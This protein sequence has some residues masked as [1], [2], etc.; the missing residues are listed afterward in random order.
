MRPNLGARQRWW[1]GGS[2]FSGLIAAHALSYLVVAPDHHER[3]ELLH[4]T[5]HGNWD[6]L[7]VLAGALFI[8]GFFA[9]SNLWASPTDRDVPLRRLYRYAWT[10]LVPLQI[11]GFVALEA[12]ERLWSGGALSDLTGE[13]AFL[14]G[15]ALQVVVAFACGL[16]L[17][18]FTRLV[19]ALRGASGTTRRR[20][21]PTVSPSS[22]VLIPTSPARS[23]WNSRGPPRLLRSR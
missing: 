4:A 20:E 8:A 6:T 13:P 22:A 10:R 23:A 17:V 2:A 5:G 16:L 14:L 18:A 7:F 21:V 19:R 12:G 3:S 15:V 9:L 1:V 11:A